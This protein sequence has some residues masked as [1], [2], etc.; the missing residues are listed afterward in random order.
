[1]NEKTYCQSI[2]KSGREV[3]TRQDMTRIWITLINRMEQSKS[4]VSGVTWNR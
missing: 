3:P 4:V 1:M 2:F